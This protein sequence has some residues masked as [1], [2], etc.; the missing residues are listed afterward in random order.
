MKKKF[1]PG[2]WVNTSNTNATDTEQKPKTESKANTKTQTASSPPKSADLQEVEEIVSQIEERS[3]DLT[4]NYSEWLRIGF[5]LADGLGEPGRE[6]YHR[7]SRFYEGYNAKE[8][9]EQFDKCL[10]A[11]GSGINISTFFYLAKQAGINIRS[12]H[13][14]EPERKKEMPNLP[15]SVFPKLPEFLQSVVLHTNT[16][17]ERDILFLGSIVA[18]SACLPNVYGI[19]GQHKV[20][21]NLYL[22]ITGQASAGKGILNHCKHLVNP[23]HK[24]LREQTT[25]AKQQYEVDMAEYNQIKKND[26]RAEKPE[27]PGEKMLYIPANNSSTGAYQLIA[28]S[29]GKGLIFETEGD[30]LAQAFKS[31]YGNYSDG[32]RKAF[33][34]ETISYF[35]R[36][37]REYVEIERPCISAMLSGTPKQITSLIPNAENGLFS[38]FMFYYMNTRYEWMDVFANSDRGDLDSYFQSL[39]ETFYEYYNHL[40]A[41]AP[42]A[43]ELQDHQKEAFNGF[44]AEMQSKYI[45]LLGDDFIGSVRRLGLIAFR[46]AMIFTVLRSFEH[47]TLENPMKCDD[48]D[49]DAA[50]ELVKVLMKHSS[51]VFSE[52]PEDVT[53]PKPKNLKEQFLDALPKTFNRQDFLKMATTLGIKEKTAE[54]YITAFVKKNLLHRPKQDHYIKMTK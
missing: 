40:R 37:D 49:F 34:H 51:H 30:T 1:N 45:A 6:L 22:F 3:I 15:D 32:F 47:G 31:D 54:S 18:I 2:D 25:K 43:F 9:D 52:L 11:N 4:A 19:Y 7:V 24:D 28:D 13:I 39:G 8:C 48:E 41:N 29:D 53:L 16:N 23:V 35:R 10:K 26:T 33:H 21:P 38:R 50:M 17:E 5:A 14:E 36:T 44:F 42:M 20:H 46:M 27:K 12:A